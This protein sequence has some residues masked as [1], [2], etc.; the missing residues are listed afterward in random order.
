MIF[1][2]HTVEEDLGFPK[3]EKAKVQR[4]APPEKKEEELE[5]PAFAKQEKAN[6]Q[7]SAAPRAATQEPSKSVVSVVSVAKT[8]VEKTPTR[9]VGLGLL[10]VKQNFSRRTYVEEIVAGFAAHKSGQ[11][12]VSAH[13]HTPHAHEHVNQDSCRY[14]LHVDS[15]CVHV[16][17]RRFSFC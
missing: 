6:V 16:D 8:V 7:R 15:A 12:K 11:F 14:K 4:I 10:L 3:K 2:E 1:H 17:V 9:K 13:T 5:P